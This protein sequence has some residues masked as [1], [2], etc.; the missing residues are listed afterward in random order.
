MGT[1]LEN[2]PAATTIRKA[3]RFVLVKAAKSYFSEVID[4][5]TVYIELESEDMP[6]EHLYPPLTSEELWILLNKANTRDKVSSTSEVRA[7]EA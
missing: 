6:E 4:L 1:G 5:P 2:F 3:S 7:L